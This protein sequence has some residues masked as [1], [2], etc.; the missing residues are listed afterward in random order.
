MSVNLPPSGATSLPE[1]LMEKW[2]VYLISSVTL[3]TRKTHIENVVA[4]PDNGT[5]VGAGT[6]WSRAQV[7]AAIERGTTFATIYKTAEGKWTFGAQVEI[8]VVHGEK[9]I[10][11]DRDATTA[12]NLGSLPAGA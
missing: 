11:T 7:V 1:N 4:H 2:A 12:D 3:N 9:F 6:T 10:R 5:T 8:V